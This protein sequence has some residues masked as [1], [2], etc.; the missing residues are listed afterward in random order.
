MTVLRIYVRY[1]ARKRPIPSVGQDALAMLRML[2]TARG[3]DVGV[4]AVYIRP[5]RFETLLRERG[6]DTLVLLNGETLVTDMAQEVRPENIA[7]FLPSGRSGQTQR[8]IDIGREKYLMTCATIRPW[9]IPQAI[10]LKARLTT[11]SG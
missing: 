6:C 4:L 5:E 7:E 3:E 2:K 9:A 8:N 11:G 1:F 10:S